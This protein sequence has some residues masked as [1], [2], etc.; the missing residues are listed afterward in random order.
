M[1]NRLARL[2]IRAFALLDRARARRENPP[3]A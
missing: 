3:D 1:R 2:V